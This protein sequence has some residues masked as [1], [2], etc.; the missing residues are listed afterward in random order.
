M[1]VGVSV[2][3]EVGGLVGVPVGDFVGVPVARVAVGASVGDLVELF[4]G[5]SVGC[6]NPSLSVA[7]PSTGT[8]TVIGSKPAVC[9]AQETERLPSTRLVTEGPAGAI[10]E[11]RPFASVVKRITAPDHIHIWNSG[12]TKIVDT[13]SIGTSKAIP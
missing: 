11:Y 8:G 4:V 9:T 13:I 3:L 6:W 10:A 1:P 7:V 12:I 5:E 2:G